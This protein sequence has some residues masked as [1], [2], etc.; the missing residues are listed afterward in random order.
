MSHVQ[1]SSHIKIA[2]LH[3]VVDPLLEG[4]YPPDSMRAMAAVAVECVERLSMN[5]PNMTEVANRLGALKTMQ[6]QLARRQSSS[7][8]PGSSVMS[9]HMPIW[10][11]A[12]GSGYDR[13]G[14]TGRADSRGGDG[15]DSVFDSSQIGRGR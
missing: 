15:M 6:D 1:T 8:Y 7:V 2:Q 12:S 9:D 3:A 11:E 4:H 5:R 10:S 14:G 13:T